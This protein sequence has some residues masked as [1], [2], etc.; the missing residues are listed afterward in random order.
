[1]GRGLGCFGIGGCAA[2]PRKRWPEPADREFARSQRLGGKLRLAAGLNHAECLQTLSGAGGY[3]QNGALHHATPKRPPV[4]HV[5]PI[6]S[7]T[8]DG[9]I[10]IDSISNIVG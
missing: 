9:G 3:G 6:Y 8:P 5:K 1:M 4:M 10:S 2:C 7:F